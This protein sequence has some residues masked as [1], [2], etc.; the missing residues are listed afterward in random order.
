[1]KVIIK[2]LKGQ[3]CALD[4]T[5]ATK[6]LEI[7]QK[8]EK[9]MK[10]PVGNQKLLLLGRTLNDEQ[11]IASYQNIKDGSKLNLIAMKPDGLRDVIHRSF[12]RF[13]NE[14]QAERLTT[15]FIS[16]FE[17]KISLLSLDDIERLAD[18]LLA[19]ESQIP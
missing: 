8:I 19:E 13:Y 1:M 17:K 9:S 12:R 5:P 16:D 14:Q 6:I 10:I 18:S 15:E 7:K 4:V 11:S 3:D 2:V